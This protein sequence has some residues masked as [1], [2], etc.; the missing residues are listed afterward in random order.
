MTLSDETLMAYADGQLD[1][2]ECT[3][4]KK[5]IAQEPELSA[6]LEV[7]QTT[8]Q[9]LASLFGE[10][11]N[12]PLPGKLRRFAVSAQPRAAKKP[13]LGQLAAT[14][15]NLL[16]PVQPFGLAAASAAILIAGIGVGWLVHG[17]AGGGGSPLA[18]LIQVENDGAV[19]RG[20][21][22]HALNSL[23]SGKET[24]VALP[25]GKVVRMAIKLSFRDRAQDYC[26]QYE[27]GL[28]ASENYGGIACNSNGQWN[29]LH[30][31]RLAPA[32]QSSNKTT[33]A[34]NESPELEAAVMS[35]IGGDA[36]GPQEEDAMIVK[37]WKSR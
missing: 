21:L 9:S 32:Q 29:I 4:V 12:A 14:L 6:R 37:G 1:V 3:R 18:G 28:A 19:A 36:L 33:P 8:G 20:P 10:H 7:F 15:R 27:I 16:Q 24:A 17:G 5:L 2:R 25:E 35:M 13:G 26:R 30:R 34:G 11:M 23:Q 31:A 22:Q